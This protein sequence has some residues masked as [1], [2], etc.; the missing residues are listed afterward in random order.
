MSLLP[1]QP[2]ESTLCMHYELFPPS[3]SPE[4]FANI[5]FP[6]AKTPPDERL[7]P[8]VSDTCYSS[9][10]PIDTTCYTQS[11][12]KNIKCGVIICEASNLV[13]G[14]SVINVYIDSVLFVS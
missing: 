7:Y 10:P 14:G 9:F 1:Q 2:V 5:S 11:C 12:R 3:L 4:E 6:E 13:P 8:D